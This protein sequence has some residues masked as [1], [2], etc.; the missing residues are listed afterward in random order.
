MYNPTDSLSIPKHVLDKDIATNNGCDDPD[1][2]AG[3]AP[4]VAE[5]SRMQDVNAAAEDGEHSST[6]SRPTARGKQTC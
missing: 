2:S 1:H 6:A 3:D 4:V 5:T